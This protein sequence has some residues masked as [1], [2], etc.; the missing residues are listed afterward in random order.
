VEIPRSGEHSRIVLKTF[1]T[2]AG[3]RNDDHH[4]EV[5]VG[6]VEESLKEKV[7]GMNVWNMLVVTS[8]AILSKP[9]KNVKMKTSPIGL[10]QRAS[11]KK[12]AMDVMF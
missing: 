8:H 4:N 11:S 7:A 1:A 10:S 3:L 6:F 12:A 5:L 9:R 2:D